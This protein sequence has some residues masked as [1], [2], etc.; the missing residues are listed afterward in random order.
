[1]APW[2]PPTR[3]PAIPEDTI[4]EMIVMDDSSSLL[5]FFFS[6]VCKNVW[7]PNNREVDATLMSNNGRS[8]AAAVDE[9]LCGMGMRLL[10]LRVLV[11][12]KDKDPSV[13]GCSVVAKTRGR[14]LGWVVLVA[15]AV[16]V[17][18][19]EVLEKGVHVLAA[20]WEPNKVSATPLAKPAANTACIAFTVLLLV[21]EFIEELLLLVTAFLFGVVVVVN[22]V[23]SE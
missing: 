11:T 22:K 1:M 23:S 15:V 8:A 6:K 2:T 9:T 3:A 21:A 18:A 12:N 20:W 17:V 16:R 7:D 13:V 10:L 19:V 5:P 4:V 14:L